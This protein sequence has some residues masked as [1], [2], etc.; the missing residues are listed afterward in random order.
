MRMLSFVLLAVYLVMASP[1]SAADET[2][3][4]ELAANGQRNTRPFTVRDRW[5]VRWDLRGEMVTVMIRDPDGKFVT[6]GGQQEKPGRG[7]SY[8]PKG[9]TYYLDITGM[10]DWTVTVVQLP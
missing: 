5:E 8:Q 6:A 3:V 10:G 7:A 2:V 9:G 4:L 1:A